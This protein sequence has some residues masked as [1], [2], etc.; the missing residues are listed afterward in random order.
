MINGEITNIEYLVQT[1]CS[2]VWLVQ[3]RC[4]VERLVK[5]V[6][7]GANINLAFDVRDLHVFDSASGRRTD[8]VLHEIEMALSSQT[9]SSKLANQT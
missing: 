9:A 2:N 1:P 4:C 6:L 3:K 8:S 7:A 5:L